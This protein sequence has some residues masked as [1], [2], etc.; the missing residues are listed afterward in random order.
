[1]LV[2][3]RFKVRYR[4]VKVYGIYLKNVLNRPLTYATLNIISYTV[5]EK[6]NC[7]TQNIVNLKLFY[8]IWFY[9]GVLGS[10]NIWKLKKR[11]NI[12]HRQSD[13]IFVFLIT[14]AATI[15]TVYCVE[16][17]GIGQRKNDSV[18][19]NSQR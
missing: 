2:W 15:Q 12:K 19:L 10:F 8:E 14:K 9:W 6:R 16:S 18:L 1:M 5:S 13:N 3:V 4:E 11:H 17:S 7:T